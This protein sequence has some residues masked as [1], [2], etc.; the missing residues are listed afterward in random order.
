MSDALSVNARARDEAVAIIQGMTVEPTALLEY[1]SSG[2]VM[3]IGGPEAMEIA[4]RLRHPLRAE[5]LLLA[6]SEEPGASIIPVGGRPIKIDGHMGAFTISLSEKGRANHEAFNVDLIL[7]V[8]DKP[9]LS[10]SIKPPGYLTADIADELSVLNALTQ[11]EELTGTFEKP[12][13]YNYDASICAHGRSGKTT[14]YRCI[15]ACPAEAITALAESIAVDPYLCQGGGICASV[16]PT[17]AI[18]YVYPSAADTLEGLRKALSRY[19][20]AGGESAVLAFISEA[21]HEHLQEQPDNLIPLVV[22]ELGSIGIDTWLSALAYGAAHV[23]LVNGRSVPAGVFD[24]LQEQL[25]TAQHIL[26][27]LGYPEDAIAFASI[28]QLASHSLPVM[29]SI[30]AATYAGMS[31][32]RRSSFF[33]IDHLCEQSSEP[34]PVIELPAG[35]LFGRIHVNGDACT[36]C[37]SC[38]S[39]CPAKAVQDGQGSPR[40]T[41]IEENCVQCGICSAACPE[42]AIHLEPRLLTDPRQ[43]RQAIMLHE[44]APFHCVSCGKPFATQSVI[45]AMLEK[46]AGHHMFQNERAMRRLK[47]CED[48]RVIDITQDA[49]A[50]RESA[51]M[52]GQIDPVDRA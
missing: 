10:M 14:C 44:E 24:A 18:R 7:D 3:I 5:V 28:D 20:E 49:E 15:D 26:A 46:L 11:L 37:M 12:K 4:P 19:H 42:N 16:C 52:V 29:P 41:F 39:V 17:G 32:K 33:A 31:D 30:Q 40:L 45:D 51:G 6:G 25:L 27:G 48:C 1:Q 23:L 22:E 36:L 9:L 47:M 2:H 43:R 13:F 8:S 21:D 38:T 50:M 34:Q 35:S